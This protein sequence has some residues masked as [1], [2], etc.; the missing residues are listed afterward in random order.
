MF[1]GLLKKKKP[2]FVERDNKD[3][4]EKEPEEV[5]ASFESQCI[6]LSSQPFGLA[7]HP[8]RNLIACGTI[9]GRVLV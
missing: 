8:E 2:Q 1:K 5:E 7:L 9:D 3:I 6:R 4:A